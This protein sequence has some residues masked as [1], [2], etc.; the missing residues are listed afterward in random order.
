MS[1]FKTPSISS[2]LIEL[3]FLIFGNRFVN[4]SSF[5]LT[6]L[7]SFLILFFVRIPPRAMFRHVKVFKVTHTEY[8]FYHNTYRTNFADLKKI[9]VQGIRGIIFEIRLFFCFL[10][11]KLSIGFIQYFGNFFY[12]VRR[13]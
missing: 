12:K 4:Q 7:R 6:T 9:I 8:K 5:L 2:A 10:L 13:V 1:T 11:S 3:T